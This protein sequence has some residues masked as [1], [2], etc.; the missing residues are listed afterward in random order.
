MTPD[1]SWSCL[2]APPSLEQ[3]VSVLYFVVSDNQHNAAACF[4]SS[5]TVH[6]LDVAAGGGSPLWSVSAG[7]AAGRVSRSS[8]MRA[9][10]M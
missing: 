8:V 10:Q 5:G 6:A 7:R 2:P 3:R 1:A 9:Y 4:V